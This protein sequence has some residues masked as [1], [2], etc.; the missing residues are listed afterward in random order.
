M[1]K[2]VGV[3]AGALLLTTM[4][5]ANAGAAG[6]KNYAY[7]GNHSGDSSTCGPDWANDTYTRTFKVV[8]Q[9]NIDGSYRVVETFTNGVFVTI[10]GPSP[11][12]CEAGTSNQVSANLKGR[13]GGSEVIKVSGGTFTAPAT[14]DCGGVDCTTASFIAAA[15]GGAATYSVS[16]YEFEYT[17]RNPTACANDWVDA[18]TGDGGDIATIC[19]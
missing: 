15:F 16:D 19:A 2:F 7:T 11:E 13:F 8:K 9:A 17:T 10:Q 18:A 6:T 12:S 4:F 14:V 3:L 1:R 5:A